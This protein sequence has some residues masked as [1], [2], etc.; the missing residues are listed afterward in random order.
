PDAKAGEQQCT[1]PL[2]APGDGQDRQ[3]DPRRDQVHEKGEDRL[4]EP[5]TLIENVQGEQTEEHGEEQTQDSRCPEQQRFPGGFHGVDPYRDVEGWKGA[6][7]CHDSAPAHRGAISLS[8]LMTKRARG[9]PPES[10]GHVVREQDDAGRA[11][12]RGDAPCWI[13]VPLR[14]ET[15]QHRAKPRPLICGETRARPGRDF[16]NL[17]VRPSFV[18]SVC[19]VRSRIGDKIPRLSANST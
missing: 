19:S 11:Y 1:R 2:P 13:V 12:G 4:P 9:V 8:L 7:G 5:V 6:A 15:A 14:G 3:N 10:G 18:V 16:S 17:V